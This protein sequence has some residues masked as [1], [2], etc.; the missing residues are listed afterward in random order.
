MRRRFARR[1]GIQPAECSRAAAVPV[2]RPQPM[3]ALHRMTST[4]SSV[5]PAQTT[6]TPLLWTTV[7]SIEEVFAMNQAA[8]QN[9][10]LISLV[11]GQPVLW[12]QRLAAYKNLDARTAAWVAVAIGLGLAGT[13]G[14][15][16]AISK[17][18]RNLRD[19]FCKKLREA[20]KKSGAPA[21]EPVSS[22]KY[23]TLMMFLRDIVEPRVTTSNM[24]ALDNDSVSEILGGG[25]TFES[26]REML[27]DMV[28][29]TDTLS[30]NLTPASRTSSAFSFNSPSSAEASKS[31]TPA[32]QT[33]SP[34]SFH[35][36]PSTDAI[37]S[38][39]TQNKSA[40]ANVTRNSKRKKKRRHNPQ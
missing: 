36:L 29:D 37:S 7:F 40:F 10:L 9:E 31:V 33:S 15:V 23:F 12:D 38:A 39:F 28:E 27:L 21:G 20:K 16:N 4:S 17:R 18:W 26:P 1:T 8:V 30:S 11:H 25:S 2:W 32:S 34:V 35:S 19:T 22:W 24:D 6:S 13:Q 5:S 14:D 3:A